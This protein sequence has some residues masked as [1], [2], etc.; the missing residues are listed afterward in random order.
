MPDPR[1]DVNGTIAALLQDMAAIQTA[2][3]R[4]LAYRQ[5]AQAI[6]GLDVSIHEMV[7]PDGTLERIPHIGPSSTRVIV[8]VLSTG[9]SET[10]ERAIDQS[11]R[12]AEVE[13]QRGWR[14]NFLTRATVHAVLSGQGKRL[15]S[16]YRGDFQMHS[17]WSDG[18]QSLEDIVAGCLARGYSH[19]AVTD[20]SAGL[21]IARG[22]SSTRL[23][24]QAAEIARLNVEH[25]GRFR[26]LHGVEANIGSGGEVDVDASDRERLDI[27][28][29]APHSGLRS[30]ES[31]T[32]RM[33]RV[34]TTP[35]VHILGHPRGRKYG[36]RPGVTADWRR[37]FDAA[38]KSGVA[39]EIDGDPSRQDVDFELARQA[40]D[41]GCDFALDSDA[42]SV[43]ELAYADTAM[44]H[45][46]LA[47]IPVARIV[48]CWTTERLLAWADKRKGG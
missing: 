8:E 40:L 35:G 47:G 33:V 1:P 43:R 44:A 31:Q 37:V 26:L 3:P 42:H 29:A 9:H 19:A 12:R 7:R 14:T 32:D 39:I 28:V 41:A 20:H 15:V 23:N 34:A 48:N 6:R 46:A 4:Q 38:A 22:L 2:R 10:V 21:P 25:A 27:V 13:R 30:S 45:A 36:A 24:E 16:R 5:A 18:R 11:G 17:T